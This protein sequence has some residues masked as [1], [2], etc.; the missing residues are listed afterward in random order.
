M[1]RKLCFASSQVSLALVLFM[2]HFAQAQ[3]PQLELVYDV[4][5]TPSPEQSKPAQFT[6]AGTTKFFVATSA[7]EGRELWK[8]DGTAANTK[9]VKDIWPGNLGSNPLILGV[10]NT[11]VFFAANDGVHGTELWKSDGSEAGTVMVKDIWPG[12]D[13][14]N[15]LYGINHQG[16][17]FFTAQNY[18]RN[19]ELWKSDGTE[20]GTVMVQD[21]QFNSVNPGSGPGK[22]IS[23]GTTL[24][25][26]ADTDA[27]GTELWK[28]D[29]TGS[30]ITL[31]KDIIPGSS[32][33][34]F[35][36]AVAIGSTVYFGSRDNT[37]G[38]ELWKSDGTDA[39]TVM[40]KDIRPGSEGGGPGEIVVMNGVLYFKASSQFYNYELWKSDG[41]EAGTVTVKEIWPGAGA[42][43]GSD[44]F[45]FKVVN[46]N[47]LYFFANDG[48]SGIELWKSDG[49]AAGTVMVKDIWPGIN[50]GARVNDPGSAPPML[51]SIGT[52]VFFYA[53]DGVFGGE[54][55]K[56]D[57]TGPGT[58]RLTDLAPGAGNAGI[59]E[60]KV[61]GTSLY[62]SAVDPG[63]GTEP[64]ISNSTGST[65]GILKNIGSGT[66]SSNPKNLTPAAGKLY[67]SAN[68]GVNGR[69]LW[70]VDD[71]GTHITRA[72][73]ANTS[74]FSITAVGALNGMA[75]FGTSTTPD[76]TDNV[77]W[78]SD[79]T[80]NGTFPVSDSPPLSALPMIPGGITF[81]PM[82]NQMLFTASTSTRG[83]ELW[84]TDG[85]AAGTFLLKDGITGPGSSEFGE[86][87]AIGNVLYY[88]GEAASGK[89]LFRT[90]G[91]P[92]GTR[93]VKDFGVFGEPYSLCAMG[94]T[95]FFTT[96]G[97]SGEEPYKTNGTAA[98]TVMVKDVNPLDGSSRAYGTTALNSTTLVLAAL[99]AVTFNHNPH[100]Y[101]L[102]KT[103]GTA[104]GTVM[105]K[106]IVPGYGSSSPRGL[107]ERSDGAFTLGVINGVAYF[108][109]DDVVHGREIWRT[110]GTE[111][112]TTMVK[113]IIP[114]PSSGAPT[115]MVVLGDKMYFVLTVSNATQ[116]WES[117]GTDAGTIMIDNKVDELANLTVSG[118]TL[119]MT[120]SQSN[121]GVE[122]FR[123]THVRT[124]P[125]TITQSPAPA[126]QTLAVGAAF[127][128]SVATTG[129]TPTYQWRKDGVIIPGA[130]KAN[131][132]VAKAAEANQGR[133]DVLLRS[134]D[135]ELLSDGAQVTVTDPAKITIIQQPFPRLVLSS[136]SASFR[137][138]ATG[139]SLQF[140]WYKGA[141][142]IQGAA[143]NTYTIPS[144]QFSDAALYKVKVS[145]ALGSVFSSA[146]QLAVVLSTNQIV[147]V[148]AGATAVLTAPVVGSGLTFQWLYGN[149]PLIN[150]DF[151]KRIAG[152]T[153]SKM[154]L[155]KMTTSDQT[156]FSCLVTLGAQSVTSGY[157]QLQ[158]ADIPII[159]AKPSPP[160]WIISGGVFQFASSTLFTQSNL[161]G[162]PW[163]FP[164]IYNITGL[165]LGMTYDTKTGLIT[166]RPQAGG[167]TSITLKIKVGNVGGTMTT[168]LTVT[169]PIEPFPALVKGA[170]RGLADRS[171]T[172]LNDN[173]GNYFQADVTALGSLSGKLF[174]G[175][176]AYPF[177]TRFVDTT[178]GSLFAS[179]DVKISR[180]GTTP[181]TLTIVFDGNTGAVTGNL[182]DGTDTTPITGVRSPWI[183]TGAGANPATAY[184]KAYTAALQLPDAQTGDGAYPQGDA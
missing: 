111:A 28:T 176:T 182:T 86:W 26:T 31:V 169:I 1:K 95:L 171:T 143:L 49:S 145:N 57:G 20:A 52:T 149:R 99:D 32:G 61:I 3:P 7:A 154:T 140:Q 142:P 156:S 47:Q 138:V 62:F 30:G 102:W 125:F 144:A 183:A 98:G 177:T 68:D 13:G 17:L 124:A 151:S 184:A 56:T 51:E 39:G 42:F 70:V 41:T 179:A 29:A 120:G 35:Q 78:R 133:Y 8:T 117:D 11:F 19:Y 64:Y 180:P 105:V 141:V 101:E 132:A 152:A 163:N 147:P 175:T 16:L 77:L 21:I 107:V 85:T 50:I 115:S 5:Q 67:F 88:C 130:T 18:D 14:G 75:F 178:T 172:T 170:F 136:D 104:A 53:T 159:A 173:L 58:V 121:N 153:T 72:A 10:I 45:G 84:R 174:R 131:Y 38:F 108:S 81:R 22:F 87:L 69:E 100:G 46:G 128:F 106:D 43:Q 155:A 74:D 59:R 89:Q 103:N 40:V 97:P 34:G 27:Y 157:L 168:A 116:L 73:N 96:D 123:L 36:G 90:D 135:F 126:S 24:F 94:S 164:T 148:K 79:G 55:W 110:D 165:P 66:A 139:E 122:L 166:G 25:F 2:A 23:A 12:H 6:L 129:A 181:L 91:T 48:T 118:T 134:G 161:T 9:L 76:N 82:G 65:I 4:N 112:G 146:V 158:V 92:A 71:S 33:S 119:Y 80:N 127:T 160:T 137:V 60:M 113:D 44:P 63:G 150:S 114:G 162:K 15:P 93:L 54:L 167:G 109:A 37:H 83:E